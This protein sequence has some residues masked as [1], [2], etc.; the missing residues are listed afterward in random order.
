MVKPLVGKMGQRLDT[1]LNEYISDV[2]AQR[3]GQDLAHDGAGTGSDHI[4]D[5][6]VGVDGNALDGDKQ[7]ALAGLAGII[8][9]I[10]DLDMSVPYHLQWLDGR[11]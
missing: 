1:V 10:C 9:D 7:H 8:D 3:L 5:K 2:I 11:E 4:A 6:A